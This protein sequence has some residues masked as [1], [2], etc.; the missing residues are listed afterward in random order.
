MKR[1]IIIGGGIAGLTAGIYAR[2]AG[3]EVE[4]Y[5]KNGIAGGQCM[6]W[7]RKGHHIDNCI[8]WLT[9]TKKGTA[10][11]SLWEDIGAL[12]SDSVFV[13]NDRFYTTIVGEKS[14]TFWR[15]F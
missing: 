3:Y 6:G 12:S 8:H 4:I 11:R 15:D 9:G 14:I 2:K 5:E 10:L 1:V 13:E 7:N